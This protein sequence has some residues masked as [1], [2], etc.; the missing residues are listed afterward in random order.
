[1]AYNDQTR[2]LT[3]DRQE[4][5]FAGMLKSRSF[6][7]VLVSPENAWGYDSVKTRFKTIKYKGSEMKIKLK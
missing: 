6:E 1:M 5:S 7:V 2:E 3:L 4:G